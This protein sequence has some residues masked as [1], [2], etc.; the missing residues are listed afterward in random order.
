MKQSTLKQILFQRIKLYEEMEHCEINFEESKIL[1]LFDFII[2]LTQPLN[3]HH[4]E[5]YNPDLSIDIIE[6]EAMGRSSE[7]AII[8]LD[9]KIFLMQ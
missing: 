9:W 6:A 8:S 2:Q 1:E 5:R 3:L 4:K 7:E